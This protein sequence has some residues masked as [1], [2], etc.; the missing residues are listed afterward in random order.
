M[1]NYVRPSSSKRSAAR[2]ILWAGLIAGTLDLTAACLL[3]W[4]RS[5]VTPVRVFQSVAG[6]LYGPASFNGGTK[7]AM[8]GVV[9][10]FIIAT[11]AAAIYYL[12][13]RRLSFLMDQPIIAGVLVYLNELIPTKT[14]FYAL[15]SA[16]RESATDVVFPDPGTIDEKILHE[17]K[18]ND[19]DD[20][21]PLL[22][23]EFQTLDVHLPLIHVAVNR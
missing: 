16:L 13:S 20:E 4:L 19:K 3:A 7:T 14:D 23:I 1:N 6:G 11:T 21:P 12:A 9:L 10:H 17:W 8:L 5:G 22:S 15:R 18:P 2:V